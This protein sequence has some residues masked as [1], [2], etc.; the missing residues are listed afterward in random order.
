MFAALLGAFGDEL[1]ELIE[2]VSD[3]NMTN[4]DIIPIGKT[5][6]GKTMFIRIPKD[7]TSRLLSAIVWKGLTGA[8][9]AKPWNKDFADVVS[10]LGGQVPGVTPVLSYPA[11]AF[12]FATGK[13]PDPFF[14]R[15]S[16]PHSVS[17]VI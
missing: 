13:S 6:D 4:Y 3:Y 12:T 7:E 1:K 17:G 9:N 11:T 8:D 2:G 15:K 16:V 10:M 5:E 14:I